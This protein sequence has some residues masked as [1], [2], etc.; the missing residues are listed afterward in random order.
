M[1][2]ILAHGPGVLAAQVGAAYLKPLPIRGAVGRPADP[3]GPLWD[4][5]FHQPLR[6]RCPR[7]QGTG[8]P[9][10]RDKAHKK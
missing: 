8:C 7:S 10:F 5:V 3:V 2:S 9:L 6:A 4:G 1:I